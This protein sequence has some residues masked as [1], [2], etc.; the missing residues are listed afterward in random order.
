MPG[1]SPNLNTRTFF[2]SLRTL[3]TSRSSFRSSFT[4]RSSLTTLTTCFSVCA[5]SRKKQKWKEKI[6][7]ISKKNAEQY[8]KE[9][10]ALH[11]QIYQRSCAIYPMNFSIT[12]L[13]CCAI[14]S[15]WSMVQVRSRR[16]RCLAMSCCRPGQKGI[17]TSLCACT[18]RYA[19]LATA[20]W[21]LSSSCKVPAFAVC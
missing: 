6:S 8:I 4:S 13:G 15:A 3:R 20:C 17:R 10:S 5:H 18:E 11:L 19:R 7:N 12:Y 14:C 2:T 1:H 16:A 21:L 9:I